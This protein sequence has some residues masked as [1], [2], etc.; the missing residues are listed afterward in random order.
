MQVRS[1][2]EFLTPT[3]QAIAVQSWWFPATRSS[4][5][6]VTVMS[7]LHGDEPAGVAACLKLIGELRLYEYGG[8]LASNVRIIACANPLSLATDERTS[9]ID[10]ADWNRIAADS[11]G[12]LSE[13]VAS[14]IVLEARD[15]DVVI[16][17]HG[18]D[19]FMRRVPEVIMFRRFLGAGVDRATRTFRLALKLS[20]PLIRDEEPSVRSPFRRTILY[21]LAAES[22]G[23]IPLVVELGGGR[24]VYQYE[25]DR[26]V[27]A[28]VGLILDSRQD[29]RPRPDAIPIRMYRG[30]D[31][32]YLPAPTAGLFLPRHTGLYEEIGR[33]E[34]VLSDD[35]RDQR[36]LERLQGALSVT[37]LSDDALHAIEST[38]GVRQLLNGIRRAIATGHSLVITPDAAAGLRVGLH[39]IGDLHRVK[40]YDLLGTIFNIQGAWS[41]QI[42]MPKEQRTLT[43]LIGMRRHP[44]VYEGSSLAIFAKHWIEGVGTTAPFA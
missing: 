31:L 18:G 8:T 1:L 42:L 24:R 44:L 19:R 25:T 38:L 21:H 6:T 20:L 37:E 39:K 3:G 23:L 5:P 7:G 35:Q 9:P 11:S 41:N 16:D 13:R 15:S 27:D 22:S 30:E 12:D 26:L 4:A 29:D 43:C 17:I 33:S 34:V 2:F 40:A 10:S 14:S 32:L 36:F 28:L